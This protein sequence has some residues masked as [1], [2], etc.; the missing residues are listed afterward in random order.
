MV[1]SLDEFCVPLNE[2]PICDLMPGGVLAVQ[3]GE[4]RRAIG[5]GREG[6][7]I[8][9]SPKDI[10]LEQLGMR[11]AIGFG[12]ENELIKNGPSGNALAVG[13]VNAAA[14]A[15]AQFAVLVRHGAD[16]DG[17]GDH[18]VFFHG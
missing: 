15:G 13:A 9:R 1:K 7:E 14:L 16:A 12:R 2:F 8:S 17:D 11:R 4:K 6:E 5:F 18:I 3:A 10:L